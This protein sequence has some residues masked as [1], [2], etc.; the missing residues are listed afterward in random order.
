MVVAGLRSTVIVGSL[1]LFAGCSNRPGE[2]VDAA[3]DVASCPSSSV[4]TP[5]TVTGMS[6][7]GSLDV[8]HYAHAG[9]VTGFCQDA[10]LINFTATEIEPPCAPAPWLQLAIFAPFTTTGTNRA[11]ATLPALDQART[12][13]V[14]FEATELDPPDAMPPHIVGHFVSHDVAWSFDIAVDLTSQSST[15]CI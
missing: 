11:S 10:Y 12:D 4:F 14:T 1:A 13:N 7:G 3:P 5:I 15:D 6:P 2:V 8:F 9:F